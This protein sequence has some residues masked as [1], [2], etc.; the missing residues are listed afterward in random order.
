MVIDLIAYIFEFRCIVVVA[1]A[2]WSVAT[3]LRFIGIDVSGWV[4]DTVLTRCA[5]SIFSHWSWMIVAIWL[6]KID[7]LI[8][9]ILMVD[10]R[11]AE[12]IL[13]FIALRA[14]SVTTNHTKHLAFHTQMSSIISFLIRLVIGE[15]TSFVHLFAYISSQDHWN[16]EKTVGLLKS[17][18]K[19]MEINI[20]GCVIQIR[21]NRFQCDGTTHGLDESVI[22]FIFKMFKML[23]FDLYRKTHAACL[24]GEFL[25]E[26]L[27]LFGCD[28]LRLST[29]FWFDSV[30]ISF[31][32][33]IDL[34]VSN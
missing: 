20:C 26:I 24:F 25:A 12:L 3:I 30:N 23:L 34:K 33:S 28:C 16:K 8:L 13:T 31:G 11:S 4:A 10:T 17:V 2:G 27:Q 14:I 21:W 6:A 29:F 1:R 22:W 18:R 32:V 15:L 7:V 19:Q 5:W 9:M